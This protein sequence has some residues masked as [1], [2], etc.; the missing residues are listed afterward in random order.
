MGRIETRRREARLHVQLLG[1]GGCA[2]IVAALGVV[3]LGHRND[4]QVRE[5]VTTIRPERPSDHAAVEEV[6]RLAFGRDAEAQLV[7]KLRE[8]DG[9][10]PPLSLVA[11][12]VGRI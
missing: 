10:D 4:Q 8:A 3:K 9:R 11:G 5:T 7:A 2:G 12:P 6:N 1:C